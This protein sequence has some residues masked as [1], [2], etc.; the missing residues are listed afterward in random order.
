MSKWDK[1]TS[2]YDPNNI[3]FIDKFDLHGV[4]YTEGGLQ[5]DGHIIEYHYEDKEQHG[6]E[7]KTRF[8]DGKI[9]P[10]E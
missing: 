8:D 5:L 7:A 4:S 2:S 3:T 10:S 1:L 6:H 9:R